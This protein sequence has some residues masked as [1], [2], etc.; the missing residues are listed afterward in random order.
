MRVSEQVVSEAMKKAREIDLLDY[1]E[2]LFTVQGGQL[3][4]LDVR[5]SHLVNPNNGKPKQTTI[6]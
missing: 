3:R 1:G 4:R 2:V 6:K 5:I